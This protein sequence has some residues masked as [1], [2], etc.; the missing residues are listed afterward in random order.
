MGIWDKGV[1]KLDRRKRQ[2]K[3]HSLKNQKKIGLWEI[4]LPHLNFQNNRAR[5]FIFDTPLY[6]P[7]GENVIT[8][9]QENKRRFP[10]TL[11]NA[12]I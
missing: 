3:V 10:N 1:K 8:Y 6:M 12:K 4:S 7:K 5:L 11:K 9:F 2:K